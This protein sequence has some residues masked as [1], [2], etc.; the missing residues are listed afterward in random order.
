MKKTRVIKNTTLKRVPDEGSEGI[1]PETGTYE[2]TIN[3]QTVIVRTFAYVPNAEPFKPTAI[4][5]S[6]Y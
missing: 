4:P 5:R 2:T 3:G 1:V 6:K